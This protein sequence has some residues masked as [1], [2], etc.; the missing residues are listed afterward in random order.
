M[1]WEKGAEPPSDKPL[2]SWPSSYGETV[3]NEAVV[4]LNGALKTASNGGQNLL[5]H[6]LVYEAVANDGKREQVTGTLNRV[7][8]EVIV[9]SDFSASNRG[10]DAQ[11]RAL[12]TEGPLAEDWG[13]K[14]L[15][16]EQDPPQKAPLGHSEESQEEESD[17][18]ASDV[19]LTPERQTHKMA[20]GF[21]GP[22]ECLDSAG[23][24]DSDFLRG[25]GE[26]VDPAPCDVFPKTQ[27]QVLLCGGLSSLIQSPA[28]FENVA[29][30]HHL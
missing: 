23:S 22:G 16:A 26:S 3:A 17:P 5:L 2:E 11:L 7:E 19:V 4:A 24:R 12:D 14:R 29:C 8:A 20:A 1:G 30:T 13:P 10:Y 25:E 28:A 9:H 15:P 18:E 27:S 6:A 21:P